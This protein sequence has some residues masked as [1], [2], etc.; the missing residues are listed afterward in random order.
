M[1]SIKWGMIGCGD[2]TEVK[3]GP[4][5]NKVP[6]SSL[7]AV[8]RRDGEKAKDY[9]ARH[10]VPKW[11]DDA[12]QLI[13]DPEVNAIYI[14]TPPA[15]HEAYALMA[16]AA[17]KP[18]Y[19]EK[20]MTLNSDS[21]IR[22]KIA[23]STAG[24]KI[25]VA[26]Y[27]RAQPLFLKIKALL[28]DHEIGDIRLV[29]LKMF[30]PQDADIIAKSASNWRLDPL[31]SGGGL[32]HDLAPHQL[33]LMV[34]FFGEWLSAAGFALNQSGIGQADDLVTGQVL[35][36]NGTVFNGSWCFS[37]SE[38]DKADLCEI[39]GTAGKISFQ[40]FGQQ[41]KL[42][43]DGIAKVYDFSPLQHVQQPMIEKVTAYF[44]GQGENPC[45]AEEAILSMQ[46]MDRFTAKP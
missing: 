22:M 42:I 41:I 35:F 2:V 43:K 25:C 4:A 34:F 6:N 21:A 11:Y 46:L 8:M 18:V 38:Q 15:Q 29:Q 9:A 24:I 16:F 10:G 17:G 28:D 27:R 32:F 19:V 23:A 7:V 14:A 40:V 1:K 3:S 26:H 33:D 36:K 44:L 12:Q 30:Q 45:S 20:P 31:I 37:V 5:F 39:I 13:D